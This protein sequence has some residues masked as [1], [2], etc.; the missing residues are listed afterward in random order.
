MIFGVFTF[1]VLGKYKLETQSLWLAAYVNYFA[2]Y[3]NCFFNY[4]YCFA[5]DVYCLAD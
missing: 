2:D 1:G 3:V 4:I 5:D